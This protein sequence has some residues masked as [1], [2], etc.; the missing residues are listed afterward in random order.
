MFAGCYTSTGG[1]KDFVCS[2]WR[3]TDGCRTWTNVT[4]GLSLNRVTSFA[5]D[6]K[7]IIAGTR[8]ADAHDTGTFLSTDNGASW[9]A[10]NRGL[11]IT[12]MPHFWGVTYGSDLT[13]YSLLLK[14]NDLFA[15]MESGVWK[16]TM[17]DLLN[18]TSTVRPTYRQKELIAAF[19]N[20]FSSSTTISFTP[21]ASGYAD[22]SI[23]NLLGVEV[24]HIFSGELAAG[25]HT[26]TW[27]ASAGA[28]GGS[29]AADA[30]GMY[31]CLIRMNG[32]VETLPVMLLR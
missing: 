13:F 25:E 32:Q 26:F 3:S 6:G 7:N 28:T 14:G 22:V 19:P 1:F 5:T 11:F 10:I 2:M 20:P 24:A 27:D 8:D 12:A 29:A 15:G 18:G 16:T 17:S 4:G 9:Q 31:E 21:E 30:T 23:V